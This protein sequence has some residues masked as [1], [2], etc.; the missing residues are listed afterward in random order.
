MSKDENDGSN[1]LMTAILNPSRGV[2][3][4]FIAI[5]TWGLLLA[6]LNIMGQAHPTYPLVMGRYSH[7]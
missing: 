1:S 6:I 3:M 7:L 4:W 2:S 5:G